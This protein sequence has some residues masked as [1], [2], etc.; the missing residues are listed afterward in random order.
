MKELIFTSYEHSEKELPHEEWEKTDQPI[1]WYTVEIKNEYE[2]Q[3]DRAYGGMRI[4]KNGKELARC[5][6]LIHL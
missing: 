5:K 1:I 2:A 6:I 3:N 4:L